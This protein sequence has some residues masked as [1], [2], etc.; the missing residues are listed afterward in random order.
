MPK[1]THRLVSAWR[2]VTD[3]GLSLCAVLFVVLPVLASTYGSKLLTDGWWLL[4]VILGLCVFAL[5]L[6][7]TRPTYSSLE[8]RVSSAEDKANSRSEA[9][10]RALR[11]LLQ[12]LLIN[13]TA[14]K[15][16]CR[17]SVYYFTRDGFVMIARYSSNPALDGV[18][19]KEYPLEQG[20]IGAAWKHEKGL[21]Y[22]RDLPSERNAWNE[23]LTG[24][25]FDLDT[26]ASLQM[27]SRSI[28]ALRMEHRNIGVGMLVIESEKSR[29]VDL[30]LLEQVQQSAYFEILIE[31]VD[32]LAL[33]TP[34]GAEISQGSAFVADN[35]THWMLPKSATRESR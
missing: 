4:L 28:G 6:E 25:G 1:P 21:F 32:S 15:P 16:T 13:L 11:L 17:A 29:G 31:F 7:F 9:V 20:V 30:S 22:L 27:Q 23:A 24:H 26:A 35:G 10:E 33:S 3:H 5:W 14:N 8:G 2:W 34:G 18:G 19:R 12:K